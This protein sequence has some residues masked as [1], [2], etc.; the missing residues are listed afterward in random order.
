MS[1]IQKQP[2]PRAPGQL[3]K[4]PKNTGF[5]SCSPAPARTAKIYPVPN[6]SSNSIDLDKKTAKPWSNWRGAELARRIDQALQTYSDGSQVNL[7]KSVSTCCGGIYESKQDWNTPNSSIRK[8][9]RSARQSAGLQQPAYV[10]LQQ[11]GNV[12]VAF[13]MAQ[14]AGKS[15]R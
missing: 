12:D 1:S 4:F 8:R 14:T 6:R 15:F 10:M 13:Q 7:T 3:A 9:Y 5:T 2:T 11:G